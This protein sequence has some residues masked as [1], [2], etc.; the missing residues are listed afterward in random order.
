LVKLLAALPFLGILVGIVWFNQTTPLVFGL[1]MALA[2]L[3]FWTILSSVVL[4]LIY[5]IDPANRADR[6]SRP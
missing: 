6:S 3:M 2:W 5:L 1:P 4:G